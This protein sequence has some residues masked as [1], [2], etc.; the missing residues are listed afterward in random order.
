MAYRLD[1][2]NDLTQ[3]TMVCVTIPMGEVD[4]LPLKT[5]S[6]CAPPFLLPFQYRV[7]DD[8]IEVM[9]FI[10]SHLPLRYLKE[11]KDGFSY[12][13]FWNEILEP[14]VSCEDWFM[15]PEQ[16]VLNMD[17]VYVDRTSGAVNYVYAHSK[18]EE[19][20]MA[21][22]QLFLTQ[23]ST[24]ITTTD[25]ALENK[26]LKQLQ[27]FRLH[28]FMEMLKEHGASLGM[29]ETGQKASGLPVADRLK[30]ELSQMK[31][32][33]ETSAFR[34][35]GRVLGG[36]TPSMPSMQ[37]LPTLPPVPSLPSM[38]APPS[39]PP[40]PSMP[41]LP[42]TPPPM[43]SMTP[44]KP[45]PVADPFGDEDDIIFEAPLS[46]GKNGGLF[47][48]REKA[49]KP[50]KMKKEKR[51][52]TG[53]GVEM[54][55][56]FMDEAPPRRSGSGVA[57]V[58]G[59]V[60]D[61]QQEPAPAPKKP[62]VGGPT[63]IGIGTRNG[64]VKS[65]MA[66]MTMEEDGI[67]QLP[68]EEM[69]PVGARLRNVGLATNPP[70]IPLRIQEGIPFVIGR[71]NVRAGVQQCDFE[72]E[73]DTQGVSRRH[74]ALELYQGNYYIIDLGSKGG[75]TL[76]GQKVDMSQAMLLKAGDRISFGYNGI[77]YVFEG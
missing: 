74:C 72:F 18:Q 50:E 34:K 28:D 16:F 32:K 21:K 58:V 43:A 48:K 49:P 20:N 31:G 4:V 6:N 69:N 42:A 15:M 35:K 39:A 38:T 17:H 2:K 75:T 19:I 25:V 3:G 30:Q 51:T 13:A 11:A 26:V 12:I 9:Y 60:A 70:S 76:N 36:E 57:G 63:G 71:F 53:G 1:V 77:D 40:L 73:K 8:D 45:S 66:E 5:A 14:F 37:A 61:F 10:K 55:E 44:P 54:A 46:G 47:G 68:P 59:G 62:V 22:L 7:M 41:P 64:L 27:D 65:G 23:I 56:F 33:G 29:G 52:K 24:I 67:T